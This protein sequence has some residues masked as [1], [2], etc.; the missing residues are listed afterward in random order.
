MERKYLHKNFAE[1]Q[2]ILDKQVERVLGEMEPGGEFQVLEAGCGSATKF[3]LPENTHLSGID[4]S[5]EQLERNKFIRTKILGD[6]QTYNL[7]AS[8][9]DLVLCYDVME[10]LEHPELALEL[11]ARSLRPGGILIICAPERESFKGTVT[12][13]TPH[14]FHVFVYKRLLRDPWAGLPGRHPFPTYLKKEM[15]RKW[16]AEFARR[17]GFSVEYNA[18][19]AHNPIFDRFKKTSAALYHFSILSGKLLKLLSF[20]AV[21]PEITDFSIIL[22]KPFAIAAHSLGFEPP[23][24]LAMA[25]Q[26][27]GRAHAT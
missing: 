13:L 11:M 12:R 24:A 6:L 8:A 26:R 16:I 17:R 9:Y 21:K 22:K 19:Y 1:V 23:S 27:S 7:P 25:A 15:S 5:P 2:E 3:Y 4:N 14:A 10:H 20:G 18:A